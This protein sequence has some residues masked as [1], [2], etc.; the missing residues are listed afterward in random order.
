MFEW[1]VVR[2]GSKNS[3]QKDPFKKKIGLHVK[4][5]KT[6]IGSIVNIYLGGGGRDLNDDLTSMRIFT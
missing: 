3:Y 1:H 6:V 2:C 5:M 4:N